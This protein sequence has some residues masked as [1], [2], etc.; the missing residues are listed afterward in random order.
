VFYL[1][2]LGIKVGLRQWAH[3]PER[4]RRPVRLR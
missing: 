4:A 2:R 1:D 3:D